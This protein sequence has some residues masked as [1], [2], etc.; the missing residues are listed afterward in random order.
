M[1]DRDH[2][3]DEPDSFK[4]QT[5][6][7]GVS[8]DQK[9][10]IDITTHPTGVVCVLASGTDS[11]HSALHVIASST[12][13]STRSNSSSNSAQHVVGTALIQCFI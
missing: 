6:S 9:G 4:E 2:T 13:P 10:D 12:R 7:V 3:T 8:N 11:M 1:Q 5:R